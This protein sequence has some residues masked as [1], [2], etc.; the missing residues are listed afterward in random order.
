S[1]G[2]FLQGAQLA[3]VHVHYDYTPQYYAVR[4]TYQNSFARAEAVGI[5]VSLNRP[6]GVSI[7]TLST[8]WSRRIAPLEDGRA[9]G[10]G[11]W[12]LNIQHAYN[13]GSGTLLLG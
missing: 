2:R 6:E 9:F 1:Y 10:L 11:G 4:S 5:A 3:T 12:S 7:F 13:A 8:T